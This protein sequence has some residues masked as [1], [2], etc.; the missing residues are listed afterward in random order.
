MDRA[1]IRMALAHEG[2][3]PGYKPKYHPTYYL[4]DEAS[5]RRMEALADRLAANPDDP[6]NQRVP[7]SVR[8]MVEARREHRSEAA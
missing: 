6:D 4:S 3:T 7:A 5:R 8:Q 1:F 2:P